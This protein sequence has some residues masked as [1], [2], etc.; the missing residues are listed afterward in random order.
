[1]LVSRL[2]PEHSCCPG[3]FTTAHLPEFPVLDIFGKE[4]LGDGSS[5]R[6]IQMSRFLN[7]PG[8]NCRSR[9]ILGVM[10]SA[11]FSDSSSS[12]EK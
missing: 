12:R 1:M 3:T 6:T 7:R 10:P 5:D 4:T 9:S 8:V 2:N 11:I